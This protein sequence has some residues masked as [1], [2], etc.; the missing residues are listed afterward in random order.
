VGFGSRGRL[1]GSV[2]GV[3]EEVVA[4]S[5]G[6]VKSVAWHTVVA[7][8]VAAEL[9]VDR[10]TGGWPATR[11]LAQEGPNARPTELPERGRWALAVSS[12]VR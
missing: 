5:E 11:R 7:E 12:P 3:G 10:G 9:G 2:V 4:A 6:S 8:G 1:S